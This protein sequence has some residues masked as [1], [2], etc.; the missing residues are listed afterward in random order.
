MITDDDQ[1]HPLVY[2]A[3]GLTKA[4]ESNLEVYKDIRTGCI[5]AGFEAYLPHEDTGS[6]KDN[7]DPKRVNDANLAALNRS[8]IVVAEVSVASHGVGIEIEYAA[9][10]GKP[11][12]A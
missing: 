12:L 4:D 3:G 7:L 9:R 1:Q 11:V 2:I 10:R 8:A 6:R 5:Q